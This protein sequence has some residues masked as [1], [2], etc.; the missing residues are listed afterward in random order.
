MKLRVQPESVKKHCNL[1]EC[2]FE[3]MVDSVI[4]YVELFDTADAHTLVELE[5]WA[6]L[7]RALSH[8]GCVVK[9]VRSD[10]SS[11]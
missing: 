4:Q 1:P 2:P 5:F 10:N 11:S 8:Y 6:N 7:A 9:E 3:A